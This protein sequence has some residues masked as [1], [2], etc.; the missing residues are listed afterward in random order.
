VKR[1]VYFAALLTWLLFVS[2]VA[3]A[4]SKPLWLAV[5][6]PALADAIRPLAE[7]RRVDGFETIVS[8]RSIP[9]SLASAGRRPDFLL[10]VG[11]DE[12]GRETA[13]WYLPAKRMKL[14]RWRT[15]QAE[16]FA[17]DVAWGDLDG[18]GLPR[19]AVGRIP[20]RSRDQAELVV[21]KILAFESQT[22]TAAD[23]QIPAWLGSP[24]YNAMINAMATR[25]GLGMIQTKGPRWLRPWFISGNADDPFCGWP[26]D[27]PARFTRQMKE[28]GLLAVLM[29]HACAEAFYSMSVQGKPVWYTAADAARE[30]GSG[31]PAP[32]MIFFSCESGKF[33]GTPPCQAK[34]LLLLPG[35]P[36]AAIGATTESHPLTNYFSAVCLLAA[37][38][39]KENR[40]GSLW[41]GAQREARRAHDLVIETMLQ[42]VEGSLETPINVEKLRRDQVLMY[43]LLGDP[44]TR[45]RLPGAIQASVERAG[46]GWR[47]QAEKPLHA[48]HLEVGYRSARPL[49]G[50]PS[51]RPAGADDVRKAFE[52]ANARFAFTREPSPPDS[53][54]WQGRCD[55]PG[56]LRLVATGPGTFSVAVLKL[57]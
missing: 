12:P 35:G 5:A 30:F 46:S 57:E 43:A 31:P 13:D 11:D 28:G 32:P 48:T 16:E 25:L 18:D 40:L 52:A 56:W 8:T 7:K 24:E 54:P 9:E 41:Y 3:A 39:G 51:T 55:R 50:L 1:A 53:G 19:I 33:V 27:Q 38:G 42:D 21:R 36:V 6:R 29:G 49:S 22:P 37:L 15:V 20:A 47:W 4:D 17:S 23:L 26:P 45:L 34:V 14:Y 44:A 10:L 2:A